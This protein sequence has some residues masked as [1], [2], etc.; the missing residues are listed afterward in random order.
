MSRIPSNF[1]TIT[2][3]PEEEEEEEEEGVRVTRANVADAALADSHR[4]QREL[5]DGRRDPSSTAGRTGQLIR[6]DIIPCPTWL[7]PIWQIG[8][9]EIL[10]RGDAVAIN[11][12]AEQHYHGN[13]GLAKDL[14][15]SIELWAEAAEL[16]LLHAH[17]KVGLACYYGQGVDEDKPRGVH[18]WQQA[19]MKGHALSRRMLGDVE[20][21]N[22]NYQI[23][24][25]HYIL[26]AKMGYE[27]SLNSIKEMFKE[28]H[29]TKA[30][31]AE[32]LLGY[33]DAVEEMKSPQREEAKRIAN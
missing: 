8:T 16:G 4:T 11:N 5:P 9:L 13:L 7:P 15:R 3:K 32:A 26:S 2:F 25:Q 20:Y 1:G 27:M 19:A 17:Y 18:H 28:G 29:A 14:P 6:V 24:L 33:R 30:Q 22:G 23:A 21:D 12:L 10:N 31:Y